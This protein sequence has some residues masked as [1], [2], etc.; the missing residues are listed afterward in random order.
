MSNHNFDM[1]CALGRI[2]RFFGS[3]GVELSPIKVEEGK[4]EYKIDVE[5][6][7]KL[8]IPSTITSESILEIAKEISEKSDGDITF[9]LD[10]ERG[11][12]VLRENA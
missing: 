6:A 12:Y 3:R 10:E 5:K 8:A 11:K 1:Y 4:G 2:M 7:N 9:E